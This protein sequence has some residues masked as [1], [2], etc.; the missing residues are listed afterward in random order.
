MVIH[1]YF[2]QLLGGWE[3]HIKDSEIV[4]QVFLFC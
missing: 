1:M 2:Q 4:R 3:Y